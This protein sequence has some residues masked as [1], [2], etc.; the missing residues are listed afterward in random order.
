MLAVFWKTGWPG[1]TLGCEPPGVARRTA[2]VSARGRA[3]STRATAPR[4]ERADLQE[5]QDRAALPAA[6]RAVDAGDDPKFKLDGMVVAQKGFFRPRVVA[7]VGRS[8]R[9]R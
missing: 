6:G 8:G 4:P 9:C 1:T 2:R 3:V 7:A 5:R